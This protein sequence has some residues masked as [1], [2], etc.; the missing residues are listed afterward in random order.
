MNM[1]VLVGQVEQIFVFMYRHM[2]YWALIMYDTYTRSFEYIISF[3][4]YNNPRM[5]VS[6][7]LRLMQIRPGEIILP[8]IS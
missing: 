8:K 6:F 3:S 1:Q 7:S 5:K 2:I 4:S